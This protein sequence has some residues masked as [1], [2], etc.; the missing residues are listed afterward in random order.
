MI[1]NLIETGHGDY[2]VGMPRFFALFFVLVCSLATAFAKT[3]WLHA[4]S[5]HFDVFSSAGKG[6]T[7]DMVEQLEDMYYL[8]GRLYAQKPNYEVR[9]LVVYAGNDRDFKPFRKIYQGKPIEV[10]CIF[11]HP[12][13]YPALIMQDG[14]SSESSRRM[15][16]NGMAMVMVDALISDPPLWF[17]TGFASLF[18]TVEVDKKSFTFGAHHEGHVQNMQNRALIPLRDL[19]VVSQSSPVYNQGN[20]RD[21]FFA[22]SWAFAHMCFL[23][24]DKTM[25]SKLKTYLATERLERDKVAC[26][27]RAF[28]ESLESLDR[29][30]QQYTRYGRYRRVEGTM[31]ADRNCKADYVPC[32]T[33]ELESARQ[34]LLHRIHNEE[35]YKNAAIAAYRNLVDTDNELLCSTAALHCIAMN[36]SQLGLSLAE[37]ALTLNTRNPKVYQMLL[38]QETHQ[39]PCTVTYRMPEEVAARL[40]ARVDKGLELCP[41]SVAL[42]NQL[43]Y[44][45]AFAPNFRKEKLS[46]LQEQANKVADRSQILVMLAYIR[47]RYGDP[48]TA[49]QILAHLKEEDGLKTPLARE[50]DSYLTKGKPWK[51]FL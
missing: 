47:W 25:A 26:M 3:E 14:W 36:E 42:Y 17:S 49:K 18:E 4:R 51:K 32:T 39:M 7:T 48:E 38:E 2:L 5:E 40:R 50:L 12:I 29:K 37:R 10:G 23:G 46:F 28:G 43:A 35:Q 6:S 22:E 30:L 13:D 20:K 34:G 16:Y 8:F 27:Q 11:M 33:V 24:E 1:K 15:I 44:V 9:T 19:I 21:L 45:E 31:P 41:S